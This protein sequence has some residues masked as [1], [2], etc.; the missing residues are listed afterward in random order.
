MSHRTRTAAGIAR[1]AR[2]SGHVS[3]AT[4]HLAVFP[5]FDRLSDKFA[6]RWVCVNAA[7]QRVLGAGWKRELRRLRELRA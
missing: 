4:I 1:T 5:S 2:R 6:F 3:D 7:G